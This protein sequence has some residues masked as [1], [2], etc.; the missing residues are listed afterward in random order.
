MYKNKPRFGFVKSIAILLSLCL[1]LC[2]CAGGGSS[3]PNI[4]Q[5]EPSAPPSVGEGKAAVYIYMCGS[6]LETKQGAAT[7]NIA[8][9]LSADVPENTC[10][11]IQTGG[12]KTWRGYDVSPNN[13]TRYEI[14]DGE[15]CEKQR[16][17]NASMP[18]NPR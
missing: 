18:K 8:E 11:I 3:L 15:F 16:L 5:A 13:I 7:K 1:I 17:E 6:T 12:A 10:V 2:G 9:L 4:S 14:T